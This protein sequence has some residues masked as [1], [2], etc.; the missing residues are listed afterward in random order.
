MGNVYS[1]VWTKH[2]KT[3]LQAAREPLSTWKLMLQFELA[4]QHLRDPKDNTQPFP[5][6][7]LSYLDWMLKKGIIKGHTFKNRKFPYFSSGVNVTYDYAN[8]DPD[9]DVLVKDDDRTTEAQKTS[10]ALAK[11]GNYNVTPVNT[12]LTQVHKDGN[13]DNNN[14]DNLNW[15]EQVD[16][17]AANLG[18]MV[19]AMISELNDFKLTIKRLENRVNEL[20]TEMGIQK[21]PTKTKVAVKRGNVNSK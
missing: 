16:N 9:N 4:T 17:H 18:P 3:I 1:S 8:D 15:E 11:T 12:R 13:P 7:P 21:K 5:R 20:E 19:K 6:P 2:I 10:I 14:L